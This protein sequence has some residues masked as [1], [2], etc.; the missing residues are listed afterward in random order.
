MSLVLACLSA[1]A[2]PLQ[3]SQNNPKQQLAARLFLRR[4][5]ALVLFARQDYS[6]QPLTSLV[7][8][9]AVSPAICVSGSVCRCLEQV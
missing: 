7:T 3:A 4:H 8:P 6:G 9:L 2:L 1:M 5:E